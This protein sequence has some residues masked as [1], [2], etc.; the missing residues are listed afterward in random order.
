MKYLYTLLIASCVSLLSS[1]GLYQKY[2]S[3]TLNTEEHN[4][5]SETEFVRPSDVDTS[6]VLPSWREF[7]TDTLLQQL[8]DT[9]LVRNSDL[10]IASVRIEQAKIV[11][12]Q[13]ERAL[14]PMLNLQA[15]GTDFNSNGHGSHAHDL[16]LTASFNPG[17]PGYLFAKRHQAEAQRLK[18]EDEA[19]RTQLYVINYVAAYYY[20]LVM[21]DKH[22]RFLQSIIDDWERAIEAQMAI[23]HNGAV[24]YTTVAQLETTM[25]HA[26]R[27]IV[28]CESNIAEYERCICLLLARPFHH[29][30]RA[31][32]FEF[33]IPEF[34]TRGVSLAD[35]RNRADIR[36]AER[37]LE[38]AFYMTTE[39]R[40]ALYPAIN[41]TASVAWGDLLSVTS[42]LLQPLFQQG[43]LRAQ[44]KISELEQEAARLQ[45]EQTLLSAGSRV[46]KYLT[47]FQFCKE[48][49]ELLEYQIQVLVKAY[50]S[51]LELTKY[52]KINHVGL[53][54]FQDK[55][56]E[57][58]TESHTNTFYLIESILNLYT[59]LCGYN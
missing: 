47:D 37:D 5:L 43:Q 33:K 34:M 54:Q 3:P 39:A 30:K 26:R 28:A 41:L 48:K 20:N 42:S 14:L 55:Y 57:M 6:Y 25:F 59:S 32:D 7:I 22:V 23:M 11:Q 45:F 31:D 24:S 50:T 12:K 8:I 27:Q 4:F 10:S 38:V 58:N 19:M 52:G 51:M 36:A 53:T 9:A 35:L 46:H 40:S 2:S 44:V 18:I 21:L 49:D 15:S 13:S 16:T 17:A 1:C 29:I 56:L